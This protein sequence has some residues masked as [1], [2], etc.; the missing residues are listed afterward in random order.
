MDLVAHIERQRA[1]SRATFGPGE[2]RQGVS[3]HIRKELVELAEL[4]AVEPPN[5]DGSRR[6]DAGALDLR[7]HQALEEWADV[8]LLALDGAWRTGASPVDIALAIKEKQNRNEQRTWPDWRT[9]DPNK[10][11][12]HIK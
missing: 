12:E 11:I 9:A 8:I 1:F 10:A 6:I 3:D 4:P 7:R 5:F 2:R